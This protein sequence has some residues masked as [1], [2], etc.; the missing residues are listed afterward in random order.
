M[1]DLGRPGYADIGVPPSGA[2]DLPAL[3]LANRL[4]GNAESAAGLE[5]LLGGIE[6]VAESPCLL[7]VTGPPVA[8][9][10]V[11][12]GR[13]EPVGSHRPVYLGSGDRLVVA[14]PESGLRCYLGVRGGID[15][16]PVLGSRSTDVLSGLGP[17]PLR[18]GQRLPVGGEWGE[19]ADVDLVPASVLPA[20]RTVTVVLGPREDWFDDPA[21]GLGAAA[22]TVSSTS[23]RIGLRLQGTAL[24]REPDREGAE[25]PSEP[26]VTGAVQVPPSGQPVIFLADHPTT[27]G[28]PVVGVVVHADLPALAQA[29]PGSTVRMRA[30]AE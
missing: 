23:N 8:V 7:A 5:V 19:P 2:L 9:T 29:R 30:V 25:L 28:Y 12:G 10:V 24:T 3:A 11:R 20:E 18:A 1:V 21:A 13:S 4:V 6:L 27:G 15:V 16:R 26:L 14:A 22:W 17:P